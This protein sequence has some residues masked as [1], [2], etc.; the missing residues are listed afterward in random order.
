MSLH[1]KPTI[2]FAHGLW[3][4]G[5]CF[6]KLIPPLQND[7][8]EVIARRWYASN[9]IREKEAENRPNRGSARPGY[10]LRTTVRSRYVCGYHFV[11]TLRFETACER[12]RNQQTNPCCD[13]EGATAVP[14]A[15]ISLGTRVPTYRPAGSVDGSMR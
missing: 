4:D 9:V 15:I 13:A 5:S 14:R 1:R 10:P 2:V 8:F 7:G 12:G 3:A 6:S 11:D